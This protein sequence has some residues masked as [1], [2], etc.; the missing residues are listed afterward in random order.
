MGLYEN[1]Q[2]VRNR[3][4][5]LRKQRE[6]EEE[7]KRQEME[8]NGQPVETGYFCFESSRPERKSEVS[9]TSL[10]EVPKFLR[11]GKH[12]SKQDRINMFLLVKS[13]I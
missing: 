2:Q 11:N 4:W 10:D 5:N 9:Y 6:R 7:K 12:I 1:Y 8:K 3:S 13:E